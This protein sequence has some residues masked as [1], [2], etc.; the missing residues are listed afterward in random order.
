MSRTLSLQTP[1]AWWLEGAGGVLLYQL[2]HAPNTIH[3]NLE[4]GK[5]QQGSAEVGAVRPPPRFLIHHAFTCLLTRNG[6]RAA[7][8]A[9]YAYALP[10]SQDQHSRKG[11]QPA[12]IP[13]AMD[14]PHARSPESKLSLYFIPWDAGFVCVLFDRGVQVAQVLQVFHPPA[15][16]QELGMKLADGRTI[17]LALFGGSIHMLLFDALQRT[18]RCPHLPAGTGS[19]S[20]PLAGDTCV[21]AR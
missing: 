9:N 16:A 21:R 7:A 12:H 6:E 18:R 10:C 2:Q 5:R 17:R 1:A 20:S 14:A 19:D 15:E 13:R 11:G 3:Q 8:N 4:G